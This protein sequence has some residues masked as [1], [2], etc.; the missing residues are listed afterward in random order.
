MPDFL[1]HCA[2]LGVELTPVQQPELL[3]S[4]FLTHCATART[5]EGLYFLLPSPDVCNLKQYYQPHHTYFHVEYVCFHGVKLIVPKC[6][7][8]IQILF[9]SLF[10]YLPH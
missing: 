6:I 7:H 1:T 8:H 10:L 2:R 3:Q 4:E 9:Y 5:L